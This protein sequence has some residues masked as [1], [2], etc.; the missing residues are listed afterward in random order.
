LKCIIRTHVKHQGRLQILR[1]TIISA[2]AAGFSKILVVDDQSPFRGLVALT[3]ISE[4]CWYFLTTGTPGTKNGLYWSLK[5]DDGLDLH[6]CDDV[7]LARTI[8]WADIPVKDD[9][10]L[11]SYFAPYKRDP[12]KGWWK[13]PTPNFYAALACRFHPDLRKAY[14]EARDAVTR[15][16]AEETQAQDDILVKQILAASGKEIWNTGFDYA[17]HT[18]TRD[19]TFEGPHDCGYKSEYFLGERR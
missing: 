13:Y 6:I 19:S 1:D 7:E 10:W 3:S 18:G 17:Q 8:A 11:L 5:M 16:E 15:G 2:R 12:S 9:C 4:G 14:I